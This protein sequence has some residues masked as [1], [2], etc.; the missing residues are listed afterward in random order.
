LPKRERRYTYKVMKN[1]IYK[2]TCLDCGEADILTIDN[3]NHVVGDTER[4]LA[5]NFLSYRWRP[6][7]VWGFLCKCGNDNRVS[8][9]EEKE[10]GKTWTGDP[11]TIKRIAESLK[12][13]DNLQ[14]KMERT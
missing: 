2:V 3:S 10:E 4:R 6:D 11:L 7:M 1:E 13:P 8:P 14:F 9:L 5:T 12:I